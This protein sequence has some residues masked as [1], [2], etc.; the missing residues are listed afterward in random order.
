MEKY[1]DPDPINIGTGQ[2]HTIKELAEMIQQAVAFQGEIEWNPSESDGTPRKLLDVTK[3]K[4]LGWAPRIDLKCGL[5]EVYD[6]YRQNV[7]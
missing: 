4:S 6:W 3:I 7:R 5:R 2:D 1:S